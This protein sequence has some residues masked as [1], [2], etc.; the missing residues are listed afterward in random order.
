MSKER[1]LGKQKSRIRNSYARM[2][3]RSG[4]RMSHRPIRKPEASNIVA[5]HKD[6]K[7]GSARVDTA[8]LSTFEDDSYP[9][10]ESGQTD[11][12]NIE[13]TAEKIMNIKPEMI[14]PSPT[15]TACWIFPS[16]LSREIAS[17]LGEA[18]FGLGLPMHLK[19]SDPA[20]TI[21]VGS[22]AEIPAYARLSVSKKLNVPVSNVTVFIVDHH[23]MHD[24]ILED[25]QAIFHNDFS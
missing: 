6:E 4:F 5:V 18:K 20:P 2:S 25:N 13:D 16:E 8:S 17:K 11:L 23:S 21:S 19:K 14:L 7:R 3:K 10:V 22:I 15:P 24:T 9:H 1:E 12:T